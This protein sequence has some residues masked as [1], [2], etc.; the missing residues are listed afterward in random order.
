MGKC[1][2]TAHGRRK[3]PGGYGPKKISF[4]GKKQK[5]GRGK[6]GERFYN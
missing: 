5:T 2:K 3:D 6:K 4:K 1:R